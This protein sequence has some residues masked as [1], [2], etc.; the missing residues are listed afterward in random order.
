MLTLSSFTGATSATDSQE[1]NVNAQTDQGSP[2]VPSL[3]SH[4]EDVKNSG[5]QPIWAYVKFENEGE[6]LYE[7]TSIYQANKGSIL[8]RMDDIF[9]KISTDY[10][11]VKSPSGEYEV[12][13]Y[14][15][16]QSDREKAITAFSK[17]Y[18]WTFWTWQ[19]DNPKALNLSN[20]QT[21][22]LSGF[23]GA[24]TAFD[25]AMRTLSERSS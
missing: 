7:L 18:S 15:N 9:K 13:F 16:Q 12:K 20:M 11:I 4:L 19:L 17:V 14:F 25:D 21:V 22:A 10:G 3:V 8:T 24:Y 6:T 2:A 23:D 1:N 5:D